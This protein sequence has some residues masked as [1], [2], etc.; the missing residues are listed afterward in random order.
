MSF[1]TT[2][3]GVRLRVSD[4]GSGPAIVLLSTFVFFLSIVFSPKRSRQAFAVN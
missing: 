1:L 2:P 4:R 3:D